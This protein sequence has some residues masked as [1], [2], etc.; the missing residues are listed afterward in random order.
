MILHVKDRCP[1][2]DRSKMLTI[3][4]LAIIEDILSNEVFIHGVPKGRVF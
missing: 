1:Q 3:S 4:N 2:N